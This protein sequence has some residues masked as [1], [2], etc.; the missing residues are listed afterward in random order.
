MGRAPCCSKVGLHRGPWSTDEDKLLT[1]YIQANGE[2]HW[3]SLPKNAG[4]L[5]CGKSC[6][7][8]WMNYLRPGIKRGN[9]TADEEDVII[10]L[11]SLLGNRWS[12]IA[13]RL[14]GRTDNEI[15]NHWNTHLLKRLE[16]EGI[17]PK[18][19]HKFPC[20]KDTKK[21]KQPKKKKPHN[22][23]SSD[24]DHHHHVEEVSDNIMMTKVYVPKPIK[25][26]KNNSFESVTSGNY[27]N[28]SCNQEKEE[29]VADHD[30][31]AKQEVSDISWSS[32]ELDEYDQLSSHK[33]RRVEISDENQILLDD[34]DDC[35]GLAPMSD[36]MLD[37]VYDEYLQLL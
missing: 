5:R 3:R 28:S 9:I 13:G 25:I 27:S 8:R 29:Q 22:D 33:Q 31:Q 24:D 23:H 21:K 10:R 30:K 20:K 7:L 36:I 2:G 15:K 34:D 14:P 35:Y 1:D 11:Q 32:F 19:T 12:L 18:K 17:E 16:K 6:R 26:T 37:K 4:L